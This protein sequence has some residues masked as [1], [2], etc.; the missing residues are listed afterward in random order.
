M[1]SRMMLQLRRYGRSFLIVLG[2]VVVGLAAAF[3]ILME[4]RLP[5]PLQ[6]VYKVNADFPT[7]AG[8]VGSLGE[9]VDVSGVKVG[10]ITGVQLH[11]GTGRLQ[12]EIDKG[13][14]VDHL[15]NDAYAVVTPNT[16]LGDMY[17]DIF[18]GRKKAG[19]MPPGGT[20]HVSD[21]TSPTQSDQLLD[22]LD[23]DTR[24]W[25]TSLITALTGG[26]KG[27]GSCATT[28]TTGCIKQLLQ[29]L[30]PTASQ[31]R[32]I[33]DLLS[34]RRNQIADLNHNLGKMTAQISTDD[35]QIGQVI[36]AANTTVQAVASQDSQLQSAIRL[37][38]GTLSTARTTF[39]NLTNF[40]NQLG[41]TATS[42]EPL[43]HN[44]PTTLG[45]LKTLVKAS[46]LLPVNKVSAF[47]SAMAP[48]TSDL[49]GVNAALSRSVPAL[50]SSF[51]GL[52]YLTNELA[53]DPG[54]GNPGFLYWLAWFG[55]NA[56]SFVATKDANGPAWR[57]NL[58]TTCSSMNSLKSKNQT[59]YTLYKD[60]IGT[61]GC[62]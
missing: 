60:V 55:H 56:D 2:M 44:L 27:R 21:T 13:K 49:V 4:Q 62:K 18:P 54:H 45:D 3:Y 40:A 51:K 30:G 15:Y 6:H 19:V 5:N 9:P 61:F 41:P 17:V 38:P 24:S 57:L 23:L 25:F 33:S 52:Q 22:N 31:A 29:T 39:S 7:A 36:D 53:Y 11:A 12:L 46:A 20:I 1:N 42:L 34:K 8:V 16:A 50:T 28:A 14:G 47:E 58:E 48:L 32:T 43:A 59:L 26:V 35:G 37:L 10:Q